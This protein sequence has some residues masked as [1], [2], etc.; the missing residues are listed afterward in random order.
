MLVSFLVYELVSLCVGNFLVY[1]LLV[2][3]V[4]DFLRLREVC[5]VHLLQGRGDILGI[6]CPFSL[7]I[8]LQQSHFVA[9]QGC[10]YDA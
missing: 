2:Y 3:R 10:L 4:D 9:L 6:R 7:A 8:Y 5:L 1:E